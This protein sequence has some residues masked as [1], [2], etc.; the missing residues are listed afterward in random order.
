M[1]PETMLCMIPAR[2]GSKRLPGKNLLPL[3]GKP[4]L[5]YS[6]EAARAAGCDPV[7]VCTESEEIAHV[8]RRYGAEVPFLA[9]EELGGDL[10]SSH[11]PCQFVAEKLA[12][13]Q[14]AGDVML[15]LQPTSPLRS[16]EDIR[17]GIRRFQEGSVDFVVSVTPIDPHYFHWAVEKNANGYWHMYF[18]DRF[19]IERPFLPPM[20]RP[21]GS[22]KIGRLTALRQYGHFFGPKLATIETP[23]ERSVHVG[24]RADFDYC[25]FLITKAAQ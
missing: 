10:V 9:P 23:E 8:A 2:A 14:R 6:I 15:C 13:Q 11:E 21:N 4:M 22:I 7:Y 18:G 3:A 20:F 16:S 5:A 19:M 25:E 17:A 1:M 12:S 24:T